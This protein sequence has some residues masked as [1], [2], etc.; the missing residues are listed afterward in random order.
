MPFDRPIAKTLAASF[1]FSNTLWPY[2]SLYAQYPPVALY[3][4]VHPMSQYATITSIFHCGSMS[5]HGFVCPSRPCYIVWCVPFSALLYCVVCA[6]YTPVGYAA[7]SWGT[8]FFRV[9]P[10]Y[11]TLK[12]SVL[13]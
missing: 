11:T 8:T 10:L 2:L 7:W 13:V 12:S 9:D 6:H 5:L 3:A 4:S 1:F